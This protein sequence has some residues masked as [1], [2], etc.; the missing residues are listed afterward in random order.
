MT[1]KQKTSHFSAAFEERQADLQAI[2]DKHDQEIERL[3]EASDDQDKARS[4]WRD[5]FP[6]S[7]AGAGLLAARRRKF[8]SILVAIG[9]LQ[10]Q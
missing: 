6:R 9:L 5:Y 2:V 1:T 7:T 4:L 8:K 3:I 10:E